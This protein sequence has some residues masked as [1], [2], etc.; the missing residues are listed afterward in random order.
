MIVAAGDRHS[1][2]FAVRKGRGLVVEWQSLVAFIVVVIL[3]IPIRRFTL[4]GGLAVEIEPYR[5]VVALI[6]VAWLTALLIDPR[7]RLLPSGLGVPLALF[8]MALLASVVVNAARIEALG[9]EGNVIKQ[10]LLFGTFI[11]VFLMIVSALRT[12]EEVEAIVWVLV[13]GGAAVAATGIVEYWTGTNI[14]DN[15]PR[16]IPLLEQYQVAG[17]GGGPRGG[18]HRA[19][20]SAEHPIALGAALVLL[21][22]FALYLSI[23]RGRRW[24]VATGLLLLGAFTTVS[25]TS[26]LMLAVMGLVFLWL[27]P[28]TV[29]RMWPWAIP[30][31]MAAQIAVPGALGTFRY[32]FERPSDVVAEQERGNTVGD[33]GRLADIGPSLSELSRQPFVGQGFGT[34]ISDYSNPAASQILDDQWLKTLLETGL[35]GALSL[36]WLLTRSIRRTTRWARDRPGDVGWL[37]VAFTASIASYTVAMVAYDAFSFGQSTF[38]LFI[39]LALGCVATRA[40]EH[41]P[42]A[43][44]AI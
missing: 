2:D 35:I 7:V 15:L 22:P 5:V 4:A 40:L 33:Q 26:L 21:L 39:I 10:L 27:R 1:P 23:T 25:R 28:K 8:V 24:W 6:L 32:W 44:T 16:L 38:L 29:L 14:Y 18:L 9:L 42:V 30:L 43:L 12:M 19:A 34:R 41:E 3:F 17:S 20:A 13:V 36:L 31:V 37:G 11:L